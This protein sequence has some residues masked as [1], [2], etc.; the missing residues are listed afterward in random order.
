MIRSYHCDGSVGRAFACMQD[1]GAWSLVATGLSCRSGND[2]STGTRSATGVSV[3]GPQRWPHKEYHRRCGKLKNLLSGH[4]C[5]LSS[6]GLKLQ[7]FSSNGAIFIWVKNLGVEQTQWYNLLVNYFFIQSM[8]DVFG[9]LMDCRL[10][11]LDSGAR[12]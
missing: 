9:I 4:A 12:S 2:I 5:Q 3:T 7:S 11:L 10:T 1:M 8:A 6:I